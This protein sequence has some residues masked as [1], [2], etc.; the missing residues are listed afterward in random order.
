MRVVHP[1]RN[2]IVNT[3]FPMLSGLGRPRYASA[4]VIGMH[5]KPTEPAAVAR[6]ARYTCHDSIMPLLVLHRV[7]ALRADV[8]PLDRLHAEFVSDLFRPRFA[9]QRI[10]RRKVRRPHPLLHLRLVTLGT[11]IGPND[12]RCIWHG[13]PDIRIGSPRARHA[14]RKHQNERDACENLTQ[15][16]KGAKKGTIISNHKVQSTS[17][18]TLLSSLRLRAFA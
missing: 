14:L 11:L 2:A 15:R 1:L 3:L 13:G 4:A 6:L 10:E 17:P 12:L 9:M 18:Q 5:R 7:M 8:A 16:R